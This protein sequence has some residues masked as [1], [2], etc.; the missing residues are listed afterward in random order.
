MA[1]HF[2]QYLSMIT[3]S[4][5]RDGLCKRGELTRTTMPDKELSQQDSTLIFLNS[6][7]KELAKTNSHSQGKHSQGDPP[8]MASPE[9]RNSKGDSQS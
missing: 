8:K 1:C 6:L 2:D 3:G 4:S 7:Q 9:N 5:A